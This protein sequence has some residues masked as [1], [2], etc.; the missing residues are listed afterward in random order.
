M[1]SKNIIVNKQIRR[2]KHTEFNK[3]PTLPA[4]LPF[5][6]TV[7]VLNCINGDEISRLETADNRKDA[8][9]NRVLWKMNREGLGFRT[10]RAWD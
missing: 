5:S 10:E 2:I 3:V 4:P 8:I 9:L 6:P 7:I 1:R